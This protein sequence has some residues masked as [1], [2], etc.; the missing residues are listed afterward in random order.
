M[1]EIPDGSVA[2]LN[3]FRMQIV[4]FL[5][6]PPVLLSDD[7]RKALDWADFCLK[8]QMERLTT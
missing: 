4:R 8:R 1:N 6:H 5:N 3:E 7:T 2:D